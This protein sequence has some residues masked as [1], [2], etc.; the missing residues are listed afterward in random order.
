MQTADRDRSEEPRQT[1]SQEYHREVPSTIC[2]LYRY[3][4]QGVRV[5]VR[6]PQHRLLT[7]KH[8]VCGSRGEPWH[9]GK[10]S[11]AVIEL[12]SARFIASN[13]WV[14]ISWHLQQDTR[15]NVVRSQVLASTTTTAFCYC[16]VAGW[17]LY[18]KLTSRVANFLAHTL[19]S[20]GVTDLTGSYRLFTKA[21]L[22][23]IMKEVTSKG[24]GV[25]GG[26]RNR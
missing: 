15:S 17:D 7:V 26:G 19:L 9:C 6:D 25:R 23:D 2:A 20:P 21:A 12:D 24:V 13:R 14:F 10:N 4:G 16:Q 18:R 5:G 22:E 11:G 1:C 8:A 3:A